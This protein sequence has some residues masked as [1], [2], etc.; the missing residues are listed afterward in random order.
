MDFILDHPRQ[1]SERV[2]TIAVYDV[3]ALLW[4]N[5]F[6]M[7]LKINLANNFKRQFLT[8]KRVNFRGFYVHKERYVRLGEKSV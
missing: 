7:G 1:Y 8:L 2:R 6:S 3:R 5:S 4:G